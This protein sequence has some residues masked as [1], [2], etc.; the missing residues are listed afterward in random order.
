MFQLPT[1]QFVW[2]YEVK[3]TISLEAMWM[4]KLLSNFIQ[5]F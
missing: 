3:L 1:E 2:L 4:V 5:I